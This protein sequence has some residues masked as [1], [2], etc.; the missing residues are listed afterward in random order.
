MAHR[1]SDE[2]RLGPPLFKGRVK[3]RRGGFA[4]ELP[5]PSH[6]HVLL[7]INACPPHGPVAL[8]ERTGH[9]QIPLRAGRV[10]LYV[11]LPI[12]TVMDRKGE[13]LRGAPEEL[14]Y[15]VPACK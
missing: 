4:L 2:P 7:M 13:E 14:P 1:A 6:P 3:E 8:A 12:Q 10:A 5:L 9:E 11:N 15:R